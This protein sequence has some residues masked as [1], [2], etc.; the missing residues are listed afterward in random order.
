MAVHDQRIK[1]LDGLNQ[2]VKTPTTKGSIL[3]MKGS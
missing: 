1:Y 2:L 3:G